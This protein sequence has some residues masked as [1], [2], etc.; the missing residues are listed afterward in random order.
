MRPCRN[1]GTNCDD[2]FSFCPGCGAPLADADHGRDTQAEYTGGAQQPQRRSARLPIC[3]AFCVALVIGV[4]AF[5]HKGP[6]TTP[7]PPEDE[8]QRLLPRG[9]IARLVW[10]GDTSVEVARTPEDYGEWTKCF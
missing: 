9:Q 5:V 1:C 8:I 6:T 2:G 7:S 3:I 10:G 4:T